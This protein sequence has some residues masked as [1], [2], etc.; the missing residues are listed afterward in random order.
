MSRSRSSFVYVLCPN[1]SGSSNVA[2]SSPTP[3]PEKLNDTTPSPARASRSATYG[4]APILEALETVA[5]DDDRALAAGARDVAAQRTAVG[6]GEPE[7]PFRWSGHRL[8]RGV[9]QS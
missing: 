2:E 3:A 6:A 4:K 9:A 1:R 5:H 7:R 8:A